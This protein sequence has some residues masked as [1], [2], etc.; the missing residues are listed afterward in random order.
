MFGAISGSLI[1]EAMQ[2]EGR[3]WQEPLFLTPP[4]YVIDEQYLT[5]VY[6]GYN[7]ALSEAGSGHSVH[8]HI[9]HPAFTALREHL[10]SKGYIHIQRSWS[11]GDTVVHAFRLNGV[12]FYPGDRFVCAPAM[13]HTLINKHKYDEHHNKL[14][15]VRVPWAEKDEPDPATN[16][17]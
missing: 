9:D 8:R 1:L 3:M 16:I 10:G 14:L 2:R 5:S 12:M 15:P 6:A 13:N 7:C 11:N 4:E 17:W